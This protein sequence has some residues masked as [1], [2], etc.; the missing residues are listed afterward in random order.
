MKMYSCIIHEELNN[1]RKVSYIA[2]KLGLTGKM[3]NELA[4]MYNGAWKN[5]YHI[6]SLIEIT[7]KKTKAQELLNKIS[8]D[9]KK[10]KTYKYIP[11]AFH[12]PI[13]AREQREFVAI[14]KL[15]AKDEYLPMGYRKP[16]ETLNIVNNKN[17]YI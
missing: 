1:G 7:D 15:V 9:V 6:Y 10:I 17:N 12:M 4:Q 8:E 5:H 2:R 14:A 11:H 3:V 16:K 13:T